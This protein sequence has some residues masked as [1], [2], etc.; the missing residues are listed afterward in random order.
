MKLNYKTVPENCGGGALEDCGTIHRTEIKA[1]LHTLAK[2]SKTLGKIDL[3]DYLLGSTGKREYSGDIDV[4]LDKKLFQFT[5]VELAAELREEFGAENIARNGAMVHLRFPIAEF[6]KSKNEARPRTGYVQ[7][8]FNLGDADWERVYHF[9]TGDASA[10]KGAH[11]NLA[12]AAITSCTPIEES[13]EKDQFGRPIELTRW[14]WSPHGFMLVT[15]KSVRDNNSGIW[16]RK[17]E[18]TMI[19]GPYF[20]PDFIAKTLFRKDGKSSDID[21]LETLVDAVKRNYNSE[22]QERIWKRMAENFSDWSDGKLFLYPSEIDR[23]FPSND[24]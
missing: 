16:K 20:D 7:I 17:Q 15:R 18:D 3:N 21:S 5:P 13:E 11:R 22:E 6:D 10:Y 2:Q 8:D 4:V 24:K 19:D 23:Y 1:T 9:G 12:I 14:K